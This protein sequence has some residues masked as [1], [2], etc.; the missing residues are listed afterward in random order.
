MTPLR[1]YTPEQLRVFNCLIFRIEM[2]RSLKRNTEIDH[3]RT[4]VKR[5]A[6]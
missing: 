2:L 1:E 5:Q 4:T 6:E 3:A